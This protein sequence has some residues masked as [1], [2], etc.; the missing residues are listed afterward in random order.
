MSSY[1]SLR[2]RRL[3]K[4]KEI[5]DILSETHINLNKLIMPIFIDDNL[6][7]K[8]EIKSMPGIYRYSENELID[9]VKLYEDI[10]IKSVLLFGIPKVKD[11]L[12]SEAYNPNG[13]VQ[14]SIRKIKEETNLVVMADLCMCEYTDHGHCG[15]VRDGTVDNDKTLGYY[16]KIAK[17]YAESGVDVVAPSGMMDGQVLA[18]R[19]ILDKEGFN[20][21]MIMAYSAKYASSLYGPFRDAAYSAP[22]FGDRKTYQMNF[23]N[24]REA[25]REIEEDILE[26]ADIVMVKPALFYLDI[27]KEARRLFDL[28][29]AAYSVSAEY[30]MLINGSKQRYFDLDSIIKESIMSIFRAGADLVISYF[31]EYIAKNRE[32]FIS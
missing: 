32:I 28:P 15:I 9:L 26:G 30:S 1:P 24:S 2:L 31:T 27:V 17:T 21:I 12:G 23:S 3:R 19:E 20:D 6:K 16:Q 13:I 18:I 7:S 14:R 25:I 11:N 4:S 29:L 5:R 8:E 10:G 22:S